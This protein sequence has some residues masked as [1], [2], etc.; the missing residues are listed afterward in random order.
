MIN[1]RTLR[2]IEN[3]G[4]LTLKNGHPIQYKSGW[5]VATHGFQTTDIYAAMALIKT[6]GG[7]CGI[8]FENG[9][10]YIDKSQRVNTKK[11]AVEIG[12]QYRQLSIL[13]WQGM[14]LVYL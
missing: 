4:G 3:G 9:V 2:K 8:W 12:I 1:I 5:Q 14:K 7:T 6:Y 11:K 10:W 13:R